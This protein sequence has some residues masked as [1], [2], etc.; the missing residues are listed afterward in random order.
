MLRS[1]L[2]NISTPGTMRTVPSPTFANFA[3]NDNAPRT[4]ANMSCKRADNI[5]SLK[6]IMR[7][8]VARRNISGSSPIDAPGVA[9][10]MARDSTQRPQQNR[11]HRCRPRSPSKRLVVRRHGVADEGVTFRNI[12][13][14]IGRRLNVPVVSLYLDEA[15][16]HFGWF[17]HFAAIDNL[18]SSQRT[19][20]Q[21]GWQP[22]ETGPIADLDRPQQCASGTSPCSRLKSALYEC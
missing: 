19:R 20:E 9:T 15:S 13:E 10:K 8:A 16:N 22:N 3:D 17:A 6:T 2:V 18:V 7:I 5:T 4:R 14:V 1:S 12:A 21:L 11:S